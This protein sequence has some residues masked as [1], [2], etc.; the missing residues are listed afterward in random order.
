MGGISMIA[1]LLGTL[2]PI[3]GLASQTDDMVGA[4]VLGSLGI[5]WMFIK[6]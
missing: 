1:A 6:P 5:Y 3:A 2:L 4:S